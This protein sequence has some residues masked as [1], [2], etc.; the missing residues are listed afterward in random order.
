MKAA[1]LALLAWAGSAAAE[2]QAV[3]TLRLATVAPAG[4]AWANELQAWAREM[5]SAAKNALK[6]RWYFGAVTGD[7]EETFERLK[8]GQLDGTASGGMICGMVAP[9]MLVMRLPG[10]FQSREEAAHVMTQLRPSHAAEARKNGYVLLV[11]TGLGPEVIFSRAPVR[12]MEDLRRTRL[13]RWSADRVGIEMARQMGF[14]M[15]PTPLDQAART[16]DDGRVDGFMAIPTAALA[17]QWS[18][19]AHYITDL[20]T[21]FLTGCVLVSNAAFDRLP[22]ALQTV[23]RGSIAKYDMRFEDLGKRQDDA[24]LGGL[25]A[26]QGLVQVP[27]DASFRAAFFSAA[28]AARE[29]AGSRFVK[30]EQLDQVLRMLADYRGERSQH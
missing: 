26:R 29:R 11:T 18:A 2:P 6:V 9:S 21:G 5:E 16:Y 24:L 7:E 13:W 17:F 15:L 27:A 4:S 1:A 30:P 19:Q 8:R 3:H 25:F 12:N 14:I 20:R 28:R 10:V 22:L 23:V